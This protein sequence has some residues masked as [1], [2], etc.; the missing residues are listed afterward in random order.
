IA[1]IG[2]TDAGTD[3]VNRLSK[4]FCVR[5]NCFEIADTTEIYKKS[6]NTLTGVSVSFYGANLRAVN[7]GTDDALAM[8][9]SYSKEFDLTSIASNRK[10]D[11]EAD[12]VNRLSKTFFVGDKGF[13]IADYTKNYKKYF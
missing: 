6:F 11:V 2:A 12:R 1:S 7:A 9:V 13:E 10:S 3:L 4:T 5:E 8:S